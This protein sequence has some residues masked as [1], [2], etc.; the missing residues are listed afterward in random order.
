VVIFFLYATT[1]EIGTIL[2][3]A[4]A[5]LFVSFKDF[6]SADGLYA[7]L[8]PDL[9]TANEVERE[10]IRADPSSSLDQHLFLQ[11][12]LPMLEL[13]RDFI[14]GTRA[15]RWKA[16]LAHRF[17]ELLHTKTGKLVRHYTQNIDGTYVERDD[18]TSLFPAVN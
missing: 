10:A 15:Q 12:P 6:R 7:T 11:N 8:N 2:T 1:H 16:T 3:L 4:T 9:L 14:L 17:V 5:S 13:Q 18:E